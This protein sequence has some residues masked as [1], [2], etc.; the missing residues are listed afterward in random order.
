MARMVQLASALTAKPRPPASV[1]TVL[2]AVHAIRRVSLFSP[3]R[4]A[5]L[6]ESIAVVAL[7][8]FA[9]KGVRWCHGLSTDP[10]TVHAWVETLDGAAPSE[11]AAES[12]ARLYVTPEGHKDTE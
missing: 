12:Y 9:G 1:E 3:V 11:L 4:A 6:E 10:I 2:Q 5:C 8:T 7:L